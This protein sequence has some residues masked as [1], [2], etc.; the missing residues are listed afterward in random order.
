M[1]KLKILVASVLAMLPLCLMAQQGNGTGKYAQ[2]KGT[3]TMEGTQGEPV[4]FA[5][6]HL[7]PQDVY[8]TTE[9]DGTYILKNVEPGE[10]NI[11]I[12][13]VGMETIDTLV[14]LSHFR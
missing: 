12:Q 4:G 3:V 1:R 5:T 6:I 9:L 13:F 7:L 10:T 2:I 8:T 14:N 11:S